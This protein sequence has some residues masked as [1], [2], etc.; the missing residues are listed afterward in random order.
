M[1]CPTLFREERIEVLHGLMKAYPLAT[2]ITS[3]PNGLEANLIP[4]SLHEGGEK[5]VL[6]A[7]LAR[8]N[9]QLEALRGG[10]DTLVVF[11]GPESY[12][13]PSW[14]PSKAEHGKVVPTWNFVMVQARGSLRVIDDPDWIL[15]QVKQLTLNQEGGRAQ[16]WK[17]ED[18]PANF[19]AGQLK[20][21][22]GIE[23]S[24]ESLVGKW[25]V[26]QNRSPVDRQGVMEGLRAE[27]QC[28]AMLA[29]M[30]QNP[31]R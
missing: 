30:E 6:R 24:I 22:V 18:A 17:V 19:V 10:A 3:G 16:P 31:G 23:L 13:T 8:A 4:F 5:G 15:A 26:S 28:P 1:Y 27:G 14:Y 2:L 29:E 12:V 25:K 21:I 9:S 11:Q 20:A 7:H